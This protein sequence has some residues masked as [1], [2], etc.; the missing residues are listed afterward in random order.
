MN[1]FLLLLQMSNPNNFNLFDNSLNITQ[2]NHLKNT[3]VFTNYQKNMSKSYQVYIVRE[4]QIYLNY[5]ENLDT[6]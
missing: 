1:I 4:L 3:I 2:R 6:Y 5:T